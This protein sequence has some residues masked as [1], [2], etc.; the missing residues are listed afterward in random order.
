[1]IEKEY[2]IGL[3]IS[4]TC[5]G[6]TLMDTEGKL[7]EL[8]HISFPKPSKKVS[9]LSLY[10]KADLFREFLKSYKKYNITSI[11]IEE[12][13]RN[14]PSIG[15]IILLASFN[16]ILSQMCY[17]MF[18]VEPQHISVYEAR[19]SFFPEY[20]ITS[21]KKGGI[22]ETLSFPKDCDKKQ[23]VFEKVSWLEPQEKWV[24]TKYFNLEV[25]SYDRADSYVVCKAGL[26]LNGYINNIPEMVV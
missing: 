11:F 2:V 14:G 8:N 10:K 5:C 22:E 9:K 23:L 13:L 18:N 1:M 26:L 7:I 15:T 17:E 6:L 19:K 24:Y 21:T 4:S 25:E 20:V 3:D 16:S 12:P